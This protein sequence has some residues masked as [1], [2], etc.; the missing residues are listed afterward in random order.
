MYAA[1]DATP[2]R[3][4]GGAMTSTS[5]LASSASTPAHPDA[6]A[7]APWTSTIVV[8]AD[9]QG[10]F[11][12]RRGRACEPP[13]SAAPS[14][15]ADVPAS[16]GAA[17]TTTGQDGAPRRGWTQQTWG[18]GNG[19]GGASRG[20]RRARFY[21][22]RLASRRPRAP[23][24]ARRR[25]PAAS[26][27]PVSVRAPVLRKELV[28]AFPTPHTDETLSRRLRLTDSAPFRSRE[29]GPRPGLR[30]H[31]GPA[32]HGRRRHTDLIHAG[33]PGGSRSARHRILRLCFARRASVRRRPVEVAASDDEQVRRARPLLPGETS[34][35][36]WLDRGIAR[37]RVGRI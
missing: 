30:R 29:A 19:P 15:L 22:R 23:A 5:S 24:A 3:R 12:R 7:K 6:S 37:Y 1:S 14:Q 10:P 21:R 34:G 20:K 28:H 8:R 26:C 36:R 27:P 35:L 33:L 9:T 31:C 13:R 16:A 25:D 18:N 4:F 11:R 2:R 32:R 17:P